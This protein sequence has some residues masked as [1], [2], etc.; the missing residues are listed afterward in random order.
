MLKYKT[1]G[2]NLNK[3][4]MCIQVCLFAILNFKKLLEIVKKKIR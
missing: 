4:T 1:A 2:G 3:C